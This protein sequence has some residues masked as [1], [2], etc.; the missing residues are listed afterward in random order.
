[1]AT[2]S[3]KGKSGEDGVLHLDVPC[4]FP[5]AEL[6]VTLTVEPHSTADGWPPDFFEKVLGSWQGEPL[7]RGQAGR[8]RS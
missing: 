2:F 4:G 5:N 8:I 1:M 6:D 3:V 7:E